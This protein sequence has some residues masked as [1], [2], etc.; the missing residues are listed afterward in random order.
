MFAER[1]FHA[2]AM[3]DIAGAAGVTK[4]VVYQH[5]TS[6]RALYTEM[7]EDVGGRLLDELAHATAEATTGRARVEAGFRAYFRWVTDDRD[8]FRV[9]FGA[10][11]RN[12]AEFATVV[13]GVLD[14]VADAVGQLIEIQGS[15]EQRR[16]LAHAVVGIAEATSRDALGADGPGPDPER[17]ASW[18]AELTWFGLRGIRAQ[19]A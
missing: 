19:D 14:R 3:D 12:D 13:E 9:L 11:A 2:T 18:V 17:L 15:P 8:A 7:L 5:F 16:V 10:S 1:G 6:K 4:P